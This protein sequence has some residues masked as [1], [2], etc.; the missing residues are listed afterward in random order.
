MHFVEV[1]VQNVRGFSPA[2][3]FA[4]KT[5]YLVLK[6]P[7]EMTP[8]AGLALALLYADGRGGD[9]SFAASSQKPGKAALTLTGQDSV[10]YRVLRELGG[11]GSLHRLNPTTKQPELVTQD[12]AEANQFLRG[13][14]GLPPRTTF[15]QLFCL[16]AAQ[17]PS[18][19]PRG[20]GRQ[21]TTSGLRQGSS[22]GMHGLHSPSSAGMPA[23]R[24]QSS[25]GMAISASGLGGGPMTVM[26]ASDIP[27]A[28]AKVRELEK[29]LL[30][31]K[32]VDN[33]QF[34]VDGLNSQVFDLESKLR[35][36]DGLKAKVRE[37]EAAWT[38]EPTPESLGLPQDIVA[39]AERYS[40]TLA[41]RDDALARL[42]SERE[43]A[44]E[45]AKRLPDVEPL[46]RSRNFWLG[47]G[48]GVACFIASFF[49]TTWG[50][51][52]ALLDIPAFGFAAMVALRYVDELQYKDKLGRRGEMFAV[53]EKK[54]LEEFEAEAAPVRRA[55][56]VFDVDTPKE[57]AP[58][59]QRREQLG[60]EVAQL[61]AQLVT[62]EKHPEFVEAAEQLPV[63]RQQI[64]L[65]NAKIAEKGSFVRDVRE[66]E[67]ELSRLKESI[68]LAR[69]PQLAAMGMPAGTE[70]TGMEPLEDPSP[71]LIGLA[72][73]LLATDMH[74][75]MGSLRERCVQYFSALTERRYVGVEWDKEGRAMVVGAS[76]RRMPVGELPPR[77]VDLFFLSLRLTVV[78]K[79]SIRV[80]LP[81]IVEDALVGVD[82]A[83]LPLL[84][85]MLKHLGSLTQVLHVTPSAGFAQVSDGTVNL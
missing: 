43:V 30:F 85:R 45:E 29:E 68:A 8:L 3:R 52:V 12:T 76:G 75:V 4:L 31:C 42:N 66:V 71:M 28:E 34:E 53:R 67:R 73:D 21:A 46:V 17:L 16:Q 2:G 51:Y 80:K 62:L 1:A 81:L 49:F 39:R 59:L 61:R 7:A 35:G 82:E 23:L 5:G 78:E 27:A 72:S 63:L 10:T 60:S 14:A 50:R 47:V 84:G 24:T 44:E 11:G 18:R 74:T 41:R 9:S 25:P 57:I 37:A 6:P 77:E 56:E 83:R 32:E 69:N 20:A 33:L 79:V 54:I 40:R 15:E 36:T 70:G 58:R 55:L 38:A 48:G 65:L 13:Q 22:P 26:P 64:E 19:R